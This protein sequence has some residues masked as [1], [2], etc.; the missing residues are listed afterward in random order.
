MRVTVTGPV[1]HLCP[2]R[3]EVDRGHAELT[4]DVV[5]GDAPELHALS[6]LLAGHAA[7]DTISHEDFSRHLLHA[8]GAARVV[9][10][11]TTAGLDVTC[12][13]SREPNG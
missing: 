6:E 12:D 4:F 8:T 2:Y 10:R 13:L 7:E 11:W 9:T 5:E 3:D 1:R